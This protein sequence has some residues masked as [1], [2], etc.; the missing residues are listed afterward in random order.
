MNQYAKQYLKQ[1][2]FN[3]LD[4]P[5]PALLGLTPRE[6]AKTDEGRKLLNALFLDFEQG[7]S[8]INSSDYLKIDVNFLKKELSL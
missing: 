8:N 3:R 6:A 5:I 7:N 4:E 2:W 1:H